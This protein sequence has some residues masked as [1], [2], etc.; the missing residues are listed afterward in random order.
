MDHHNQK[1][2][3]IINDVNISASVMDHSAHIHHDH[4]STSHM[5][6]MS[7][8]FGFS[9]TVLF[10]FWVVTNPIGLFLQLLIEESMNSR[11]CTKR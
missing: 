4:S 6:S 11:T 10:N 2:N 9:E 1:M 5:H 8:H 3:H 7:F